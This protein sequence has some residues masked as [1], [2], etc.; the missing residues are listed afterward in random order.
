MST[1]F[2]SGLKCPSNEPETGQPNRVR[3]H[4]GAGGKTDTLIGGP[5]SG[6]VLYGRPETGGTI[7]FVAWLGLCP[8]GSTQGKRQAPG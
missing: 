6:R 4:L 3:Q 7:S 5:E 1:G 2:R 8:L